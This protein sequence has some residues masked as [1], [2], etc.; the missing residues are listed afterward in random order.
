MAG[1]EG[2]W[3]RFIAPL[4]LPF[5]TGSLILVLNWSQSSSGLRPMKAKSG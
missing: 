3:R 5:F 4:V 2:T 1:R